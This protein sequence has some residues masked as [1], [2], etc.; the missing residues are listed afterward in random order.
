MKAS[1]FF[2]VTTFEKHAGEL[3][4]AVHLEHLD[5]GVRRGELRVG[6]RLRGTT[7]PAASVMPANG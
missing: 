1:P 7:F 4:V 5:E 2:R 3:E 6:Y